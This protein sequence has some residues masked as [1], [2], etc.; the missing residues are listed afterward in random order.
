[1]EFMK[2]PRGIEERSMAI[3][4]ESVPELQSLAL[5]ERRVIERVVHTTGDIFYAGLVRISPGA[6][7]AG[8]AA[9]RAGRSI[10]TDV[11]MLKA[12]LNASRLKKY[13]VTVNCYINDPRTAAEARQQGVTRAMA[14]MRLAAPELDGG[15]AAIGNAPTALFTLCELINHGTASPALVVGTPVGFVGAAESKEVLM[16]MA[17][18]HVTVPGTK[19]GSTIAVAVVNALLYLA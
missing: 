7:A 5:E 18:P 14:A 9:I 4:E 3:I 19:G 12:G 10:I 13:G 17:V 15:I 8:L 2:D 1:M 6:V 11:N 16:K